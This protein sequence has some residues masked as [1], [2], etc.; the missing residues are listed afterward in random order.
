M[1]RQGRALAVAVTAWTQLMS[2]DTHEGA[3]TLDAVR[4]FRDI[5]RGQGPEDVPLVTG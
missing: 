1:R 4:D 3:P 5:Y 2:C